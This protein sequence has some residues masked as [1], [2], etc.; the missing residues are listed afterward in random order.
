MSISLDD[1]FAR[2]RDYHFRNGVMVPYAPMYGD[3]GRW[4][5]RPSRETLRVYWG[6]L[7][8]LVL[9]ARQIGVLGLDETVEPLLEVDDD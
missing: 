3:A 7:D 4:R 5:Y 8:S 1:L 6:S 2:L 9:H